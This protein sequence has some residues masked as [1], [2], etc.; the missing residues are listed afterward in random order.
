MDR[1]PAPNAGK[2]GAQYGRF[3]QTLGINDGP[4]VQTLARL[5]KRFYIVAKQLD[6][7]LAPVGATLHSAVSRMVQSDDPRAPPQHRWIRIVDRLEFFGDADDHASRVV[8]V[9]LSYAYRHQEVHDLTATN[10]LRLSNVLPGAGDG[11]HPPI[12]AAALPQPPTGGVVVAERRRGPLPSPPSGGQ[13]GA[14]DAGGTPRGDPP[15]AATDDVSLAVPP[16]GVV[17]RRDGDGLVQN[18]NDSPQVAGA[19]L[20]QQAGGAPDAAASVDMDALL[21]DGGIVVARRLLGPEDAGGGPA[22]EGS[23]LSGNPAAPGVAVRSVIFLDDAA[24]QVVS[25][26][27]P[28]VTPSA[29]ALNCVNTV[30]DVMKV[31]QDVRGVLEQLVIDSLLCFARLHGGVAVNGSSGVPAADD[32]VTWK[33][34]RKIAH[35]WWPVWEGPASSGKPLPPPGTVSYLSHPC[36]AVRSSKWAIEVDM[37]G[38][39]DAIRALDVDSERYFE[40]SNLPERECVARLGPKC[41]N[42]VAPLGTSVATLLLMGTKEASFCNVLNE[43]VAVGRAPAPKSIPVVAA[44]CHEFETAGL[45]DPDVVVPVAQAPSA[46]TTMSR[47]EAVLPRSARASVADPAAPVMGRRDVVNAAVPADDADAVEPAEAADSDEGR[48]ARDGDLDELAMMDRYNEMEQLLAEE[49]EAEAAASRARRLAVRRLSRPP[50]DAANVQPLGQDGG[51][52][53]N[54]LPSRSTDNPPHADDESQIAQASKRQRV[55][56]RP[57][58]DPGASQAPRPVVA[59]ARPPLHLAPPRRPAGY[60]A[61]KKLAVRSGAKAPAGAATSQ[62]ARDGA[63]A[64]TGGHS[65]AHPVAASAAANARG[66]PGGPARSSAEIEAQRP[67]ASVAASS[68]CSIPFPSLFETPPRFDPLMFDGSGSRASSP[69][70]SDQLPSSQGASPSHARVARVA[71]EALPALSSDLVQAFSS[72]QEMDESRRRV[73]ASAAATK[74]GL[75]A[76]GLLPTLPTL[77]AMPDVDR[78]QHQR[79]GAVPNSVRPAAGTPGQSS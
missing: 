46:A 24:A 20:A 12:A 54:T 60:V 23:T 1:A 61:S 2:V 11:V 33:T 39:N 49:K 74:S 65:P 72:V 58:P 71:D 22:V 27:Q 10:A 52:R 3:F 21:Q 59:A 45:D 17:V 5:L 76:L 47:D 62:Q 68:A 77:P 67:N 29:A 4:K 16:E 14:V 69:A 57:L 78:E 35:R 36:R 31:R 53:P 42:T 51:T 79:H 8:N 38:V 34:V 66:G 73:A 7:H 26:S 32:S 19:V 41:V 44:T 30:L 28:L 40:K 64:G 75:A 70:G 15:L 43:L 56:S 63:T 50:V 55:D 13:A 9:G 48:A 6:N 25:S 37:T 18:G